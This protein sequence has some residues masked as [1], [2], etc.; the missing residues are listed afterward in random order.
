[1]VGEGKGTALM[2]EVRRMGG[3]MPGMYFYRPLIHHQAGVYSVNVVMYE[4][5]QA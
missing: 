4:P 2:N 5:A 1:M 3:E